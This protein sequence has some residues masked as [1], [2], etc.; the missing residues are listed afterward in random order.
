MQVRVQHTR[1]SSPAAACRVHQQT[2]VHAAHQAAVAWRQ[3]GG[4]GGG[5][6]GM[7]ECTARARAALRL[8]KAGRATVR[9]RP[10]APARRPPPLWETP[11]LTSGNALPRGAHLNCVLNRWNQ[12]RDTAGKVTVGSSSCWSLKDEDDAI[13]SLVPLRPAASAIAPVEDVWA[14]YGSVLHLPHAR[15]VVRECQLRWRWWKPRKPVPRVNFS[16]AV[17]NRRASV[18][19]FYFPRLSSRF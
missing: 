3:R 8:G 4:M 15:N 5:G 6:V 7:G 10:P 14:R 1:V 2:R 11:A 19:V 12:L 13:E 9:N 17:Y 16:S 18:R